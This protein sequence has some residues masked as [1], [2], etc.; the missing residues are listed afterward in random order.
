MENV[1]EVGD[2]VY[3]RS[4]YHRSQL[5]LPREAALVLEVKRSNYRLLYGADVSC[6]LPGETL[7]RV[8]GEVHGE[9]LGGK[10]HG[11]LKRLHPLDCELVSDGTEHRATLRI[12]QLDALLVDELRDFLGS[13]FVSLELVPEGMAFMLAEVRFRA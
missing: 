1:I 9:T 4:A 2:F 5:G 3:C 11:I 12:D 6:W 8:E 7:V 13:D 10:L